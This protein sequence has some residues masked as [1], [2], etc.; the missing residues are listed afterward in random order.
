MQKLKEAPE[1]MLKSTV[2][3]EENALNTKEES[4]PYSEPQSH[5]IVPGLF[6]N[7]E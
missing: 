4:L 3:S 7:L 5:P 2:H 1:W 6:I